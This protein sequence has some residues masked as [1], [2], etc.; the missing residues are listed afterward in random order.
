MDNQHKQ[1]KGYRDL[2]Q[3]EIDLMNEIKVKGQ[4]L[5]D[6]ADRLLGRCAQQF[7]DTFN[8]SRAA[9]SDDSTERSEYERLINA[10][11]TQW[12]L[13]GKND[14]QVGVMKLVRAVAQPTAC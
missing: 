3:Q 2:S 13:D 4:E 12:A 9:T 5:I 10:N 7:N 1:I 6:L 14:V 8:A 11:P